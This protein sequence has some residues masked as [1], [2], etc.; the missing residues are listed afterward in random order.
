[1]RLPRLNTKWFVFS[2]VIAA[3]SLAC[4]WYL[5]KLETAKTPFDTG[6][7]ENL[8]PGLAATY[9]DANHRVKL[10]TPTPNFYLEPHESLHPSLSRVFEAEWTGL[11]SILQTGNYTI[12]AGDAHVYIDGKKI[13]GQ[14]VQLSAG[15]H[16]IQIEYHRRPGSAKLQLRW[17]AEHF[18][19]EPIPSFALSH[20]SPNSI[21]PDDLVERGR[22]LVQEFG[23]V[24]CH[25]ADSESLKG[26][27]AP[28]LTGIGSRTNA[29]WL[30][31]WLEN[32]PAFR[33][34]AVMPA[35]LDEQQRRDV[36]SYLMALR[37]EVPVDQPT[38]AQ[39]HHVV[40]GKQLYG[41][42]GCAACHE[43]QG[44]SLQGMGSKTTVAPLMAYLKDPARVDPSGHMPSLMLSDEEAFSLAALLIESRNPEFEEPVQKGDRDR[45]QM[46]V[47][48]QGCLGCHT[49]RTERSITNQHSAPPLEQLADNNGCLKI[50]PARGLPRYHLSDDQRQALGAFLRSYRKHPDMSPAPV[51]QFYQTIGQF[52]CVACH[53]VDHLGPTVT[54]AEAVPPLTAA[55]TKLRTSWIEQ[56]LMHRQRVRR[57]LDLRMPHYD[58]G[59]V[60]LLVDGFAKASGIEPGR[61]PT[62]PLPTTQQQRRG[63]Q[64]IGNDASKGGLACIRCHDWGQYEAL[65]E[66]GPQLINVTDRLRY[67]WFYRFILNPGRI[68]SG[69]SMPDHFTEGEPAKAD[70][71]ITR[72]W[73]A[74]S[75][76]EEMSLPDGLDTV[77][78]ALGRDAKPVPDCEPVIIRCY[79]PDA[80][81]AAIAVGLPGGVSY[82]FDAGECQLRYVWRGGFIDLSEWLQRK[83]SSDGYTPR[84]RIIGEI[85]Y[86]SDE[87]PL[88]VD[89][90]TRIPEPRFR[91]Y[92]LLDGYP[93]FH[94]RLDG[95]DVYERVLPTGK[96]GGISRA[97]TISRVDQPMWFVAGQTDHSLIT[98]TIGDLEDGKLQI[99]YGDNVR[100][101]VTI[102]A[103]EESF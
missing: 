41:S 65:G 23:C 43:Q 58:S 84:A 95:I 61:R 60:Q 59:Q 13:G 102:T 68:Y 90:L 91:G 25:A 8:I 45:G 57:W 82:C 76:G 22:Y 40:N 3:S 2:V 86:R 63:I 72:L 77:E 88:R 47:Q 46:L 96:K 29:K 10:S 89:R 67:D 78:A 36:L 33:S 55:G 100:F 73:A 6:Q 53:Q 44:L 27:I 20:S 17:E 1:M 21:G 64:M 15:R 62:A 98:S 34:G 38:K 5:L 37:E 16:S 31:K 80:T 70:E 71:A 24:N 75:M 14:P 74:L 85:F 51:Y 48:S 54:L 94:Y 99:P 87:F 32:P 26:R 92:R 39:P 42:L 101:E 12:E 49:L 11:I 83:T 9:S 97:F 4:F 81:S 35:M 79:M 56:V 30:Y 66:R 19:A 69:T 52:R 28:D 50:P 7:G 18:A 93:E 103:K